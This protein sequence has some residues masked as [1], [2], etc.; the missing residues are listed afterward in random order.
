MKQGI[1]RS[2]I[3]IVFVTSPFVSPSLTSALQEATLPV[4]SVIQMPSSGEEN[5][6]LGLPPVVLGTASW[7]SKSSPKIKKRT[8]SAEIF[9]DKRMTCASWKFPLKT[10][11]RITNLDN[12]KSVICVVNDRGPAKRLGRA[13]DLTRAAF[14]KISDPRK[15]LVTVSVMPFND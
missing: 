4:A 15:G 8:A 6:A 2:L 1:R 10:R 14:K 12:G 7:Y 9:D 3:L 13:I 5:M 11:L